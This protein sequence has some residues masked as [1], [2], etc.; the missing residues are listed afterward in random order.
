MSTP[1]PSAPNYG[2]VISGGTFTGSNIGG[3]GAVFQPGQA[4]PAGREEL[5]RL[6]AQVAALL[7]LVEQHAA[8]L[9]Q[10]R[11]ARRDLEEVLAEA[12]AAPG[13]R[14]PARVTAAL[15]RLATRLSPVTALATALGPIADLASALL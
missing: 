1:D 12:E 6:R 4:P 2:T 13:E 11:Q 8:E 10:A 5:E 3:Q 7:A 14:D 15:D 9:P